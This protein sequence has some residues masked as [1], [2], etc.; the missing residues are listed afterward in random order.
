MQLKTFINFIFTVYLALTPVFLAAQEQATDQ[1][2]IQQQ[3]TDNT[4]S[5]SEQDWGIAMGMRYAEIPYETGD[6]DRTVTD[7]VPLLFYD[8]D[9][10]YIRGLEGGL[11]IINEDQWKLNAILRYRFFDIPADIQNQ[12]KGDAWDG[13][14]QIR[15]RMGDWDL[16]TEIM[17]DG[18]A[19]LY[20]DIGFDT[21][22]GD[23]YATL[24][25]YLGL[26]YKTSEFNT[27]YYGF[28]QVN[29]SSGVDFHAHIEGRYHL[30]SN[31]YAIGRLGG[32]VLDSNARKSPFVQESARWETY[33]G[34]AFFNNPHKPRKR[35]LRN[36]AYLRLAHGDATPSNLGEILQG[37][38][39]SDPFNNQLTSLFYG[40][41]LTDDLFGLPLDIYFVSG[42]VYHH[43]SEVQENFYE[44]VLG[45]KA[46]YTITW[47]VRWR[48]GLA[49]GMSY[50]SQITYIERTELEA[51]GY[52]PSKLL[53]YLD[54]TLDIN[55]G[56]IFNAKS[57]KNTWLGYSIHHRSGI[58]ETG[59]QFGRIKG[60]S[61]YTT[62][63]LQHHF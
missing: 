32:T 48:F 54:F 44:Y 62:F 36:N 5:Y 49:E 57:L 28:E 31:L 22:F 29:V 52:R 24:Y 47:P 33:V 2:E 61:N 7:V 8:N 18:N 43:S 63:Y 10:F 16:R 25:P 9:L 15:Y 50:A 11:K 46:D 3:E 60:G 26:R 40:H 23:K 30:I 51:K 20:T 39:E 58:F 56:D 1:G 19:N 14:A 6:G 34:I 21:I 59:S 41:P 53:N 45:I 27:R 55:I 38:R 37:D 42:L 4:R 12:V 35:S 13:G 17:T